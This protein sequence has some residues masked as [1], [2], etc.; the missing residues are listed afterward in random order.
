MSCSQPIVSFE[1][2]SGG[3]YTACKGLWA[4]PVKVAYSILVSGD[5]L[6]FAEPFNDALFAPPVEP[7]ELEG[8]SK[9]EI[10]GRNA[11][12]PEDLLKIS[13]PVGYVTVAYPL[14]G[15]GEIRIVEISDECKAQQLFDGEEKVMLADVKVKAQLLVKTPATS[16]KG[17]DATPVYDGEG[18]L[19]GSNLTL[20]SK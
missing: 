10:A 2:S 9:I 1:I 3:L 20:L 16:E 14:S 19:T 4:G 15:E 12:L 11:C 13:I 5:F 6:V 18:K 8:T 7:F 17:S